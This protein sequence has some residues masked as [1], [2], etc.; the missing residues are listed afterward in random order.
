MM[1]ELGAE[2]GDDAAVTAQVESLEAK[3]IGT[4]GETAGEVITFDALPELRGGSEFRAYLG[5][6]DVDHI[7]IVSRD[8]ESGT[9]GRLLQSERLSKGA[10]VLQVG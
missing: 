4:S 8:Q 7:T 1:G 6:V 3:D 5:S 9:G 10:S 2:S